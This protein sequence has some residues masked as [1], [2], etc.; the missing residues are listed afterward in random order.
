MSKNPNNSKTNDEYAATWRLAI[1]KFFARP[2]V[3]ISIGV[4][5]LVSVV[6]TLMELWLEARIASG[7]P[8][9]LGNY[10]PLNTFHLEWMMMLND[11]ITIVF[12]VELF[13][14]F[15]GAASKR[16]F[17]AEFWLDIIATLP[18]FRVFRTVRALRLLRLI[19]LIRLLGVASRLSSHFPAI[20]RRGAVDF[21][22]ICGLLLMAVVFGTAGMTIFEN[23][24]LHSA[25]APVEGYDPD[26]F[27]MEGSFWFSMYTL[28]SGEPIPNEPKTLL[29]KIVTLFLMFMGLTIFA[30]FA[31][32]VSAFMVDRLRTE[33]RVIRMNDLHDHIVVCGWTPKT[34]VI[35][36]EYRANKSTRNLPIVIITE[37]DIDRI[38]ADIE[39]LP[40]VFLIHDD[41]TKMSAL[42][43]A[44]ISNAR[45]CIVL[46]DTTGGRS[47]QDADARTIL[48]SLTVE[49][50]NPD[51]YT[52]AELFNR[53]YGTHL[54]MGQVNE[55]VVSEEYGA[56]VI[57]QA[58]MHR[59]LINVFAELLTYR[60]GNEFM[61][62][63]IPTSWEGKKFNDML[64]ELKDTKNA[65]LVAVH[66]EDESMTVN[67][68]N[69]TFEKGDQVV[70][71][72]AES[73]DPE[74]LDPESL[75]L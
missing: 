30:I 47:E 15:L 4:L 39:K 12:V 55:F 20:F 21:L 66:S 43:R 36:R 6:L 19:R 32:T 54:E 25:V 44:C 69:H 27:D 63:P 68:E 41:F 7:M 61:R 34:E 18:L 9:Y 28:L 70:V 29:G 51:V 73:L 45:I 40:N 1:R 64:K 11:S 2:V 50:V 10:G 56:Y 14:R 65:I 26:D 42:Q 38:N 24:H 58:G 17:F 33:G 59:G 62:I 31:G 48:A 49:K 75:D 23:A 57:A 52:C 71:I 37:T 5:V 60:H 67:P 46:A 53:S 72:C 22:T 8:T 3:E 74:S 35:L 16:Q 13:L